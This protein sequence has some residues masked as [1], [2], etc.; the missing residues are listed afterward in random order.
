M[1]HTVKKFRRDDWVSYIAF[2]DSDI[3]ILKQPRP[4][5]I[6]EVLEEESYYDYRIFIDGEGAIKNVREDFLFPLEKGKVK[7]T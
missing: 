6:L 4:A 2:P 3:E 7:T 1:G 5:V